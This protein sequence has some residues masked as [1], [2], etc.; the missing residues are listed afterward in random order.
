MKKIKTFFSALDKNGE[1]WLL[2]FF[3]SLL[4]FSVFI[5][6]F[7][8][9]ILSY[10][11]I[12]GEEI[13]RYSFI[14]LAWIATAAAIRDKSHICIDVLTLVFSDKYKNLTFVVSG[15]LTLLLSGYAFFWSLK[16]VLVS[17]EFQSVTHGLRISQAFFSAAVP[18]GVALI[19]FRTFAKYLG[20]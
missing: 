6:V 4:V 11:S 18:F 1:R 20:G 7:R 8:R 16:T 13:A 12:W 2:L 19:I 15:L 17:I 10:S 14:Y 3:Y 5:E 9:F